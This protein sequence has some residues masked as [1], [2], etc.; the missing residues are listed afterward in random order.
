M[1]KPEERRN[2]RERLLATEPVPKLLVRLGVPAVI[3][4][5]VNALYN[6]VDTIFV[7]QG[8]GV[9][10]IGGLAIAFP[11][12]IFLFALAAMIGIG[13]A[14]IVSRALGAK[15]YERANRTAANAITYAIVSS[16]ALTAIGYIFLDRILLIFGATEGIAGYAQEYL[17]VVMSGTM[18]LVFSVV[19]NNLIRA[20]GRALIAMV[21]MLIGAVVN[22]I[23]DPIFIFVLDMGVRGAAIAT[24][25]GKLSSFVFVLAYLLRG[26]SLLEMKARDFIPRF[27][28]WREISALGVPSFIRQL[29]GSIL[30]IAVNNVLRVHGGAVAISVFGA[31]NRLLMFG[32]MPIFGIS[33]GFQPV[34]GFNYGAHLFSR[35]RESVRVSIIGTTLMGVVFFILVM[36]IPGLIMRMFADDPEMT[37]MGTT[38]L[39]LIVL[40]VPAVGLQLIGST[41]FMAIGKALPAFFLSLSR[42]I[43]FLI[44][45]VIILPRFLGVSGVWVSFPIA[46]A[47]STLLTVLF[48]TIELRRMKIL[49]GNPASRSIP[50]LEID[51]SRSE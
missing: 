31:V 15:E 49:E 3:G 11:Y 43:I 45:L 42:Q 46:D 21:S 37:R 2:A 36:A 5:F 26:G 25:I 1:V 39:R 32:M 50:E 35:V 13:G 28:I 30:A 34:A 44:P 8:V 27:A 20:E 7:G 16:L 24:V 4:M 10:A 17:S 12:Q 23:L 38:A 6:L 18:F 41:F 48:L 22:I 33:Q 14:S 51:N 29:G 47:L 19:G 40:A 9:S